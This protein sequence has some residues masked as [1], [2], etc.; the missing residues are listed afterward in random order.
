MTPQ[1]PL[2]EKKA[3]KSKKFPGAQQSQPWSQKELKHIVLSPSGSLWVCRQREPGIP[4]G[5]T[6]MDQ[7]RLYKAV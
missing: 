7:R 5:G 6:Q 4:M 2:W 1:V 3:D